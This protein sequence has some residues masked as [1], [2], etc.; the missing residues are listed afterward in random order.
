VPIDVRKRRGK[1]RRK[2]YEKR[3]WK[4]G[5]NERKTEWSQKLETV[6]I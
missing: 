2:N 3:K 5:L 1:E 6:T 4:R